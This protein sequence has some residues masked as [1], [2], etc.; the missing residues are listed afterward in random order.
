MSWLRKLFG[1]GDDVV[2]HPA[3]P[4]PAPRAA[5]SLA[6]Q[7]ILVADTSI[8]F[9]MVARMVIE[10]AGGT[11]VCVTQASDMEDAV[12]RLRPSA[13]LLAGNLGAG[14]GAELC[15]S[16]REIAPGVRLVL[17]RA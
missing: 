9:H 13:V 11:V 17:M 3:A 4:A 16:L 6:G 14:A 8:T 10:P 7:T 15:L 5:V 12:R 2:R 1:G